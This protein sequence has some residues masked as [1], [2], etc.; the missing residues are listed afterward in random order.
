MELGTWLRKHI[1]NILG[2]LCSAEGGDLSAAVVDDAKDK[3]ITWVV[4]RATSEPLLQAA[5]DRVDN[6]EVRQQSWL[7]CLGV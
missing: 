4:L 5:V 3:A 2:E 7:G 1:T 6:Y